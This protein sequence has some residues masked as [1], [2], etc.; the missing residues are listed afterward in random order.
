MVAYICT[1]HRFPDK[2]LAVAV[3][4]ESDENIAANAPENAPK[5]T[6]ASPIALGR[7]RSTTAKAHLFR[8]AHLVGRLLLKALERPNEFDWARPLYLR[9]WADAAAPEP[10][11]ESLA[12]IMGISSAA[13]EDTA[14][15][16]ALHHSE[17]VQPT[18][19]QHSQDVLDSP[20]LAV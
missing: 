1:C 8:H 13:Y 11:T 12:E 3:S 15:W 2:G 4:S 19:P 14:A 7:R 6:K 10:T 20:S 9:K 17:H 5:R 18:E 16:P